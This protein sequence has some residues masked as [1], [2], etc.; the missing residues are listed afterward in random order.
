VNRPS[1][2]WSWLNRRAYTVYIIHPVVLVGL[3]L[4]LRGWTAPPLAK[5]LFV[6]PLAC[7]CCWLVADPLVRLPA[8][9]RIV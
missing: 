1:P 5:W 3:S 8:V 6:G 2:L 4:L 9:R 7:L